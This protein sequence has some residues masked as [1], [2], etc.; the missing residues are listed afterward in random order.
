MIK[1]RSPGTH[2][3]EIEASVGH[4]HMVCKMR[5]TGEVIDDRGGR[6]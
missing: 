6:M 5:D 4:E 3:W 1:S 2:E